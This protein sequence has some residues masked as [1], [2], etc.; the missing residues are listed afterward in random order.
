MNVSRARA[1]ASV[2]FQMRRVA[3]DSSTAPMERDALQQRG[4]R[5]CHTRAEYLVTSRR[6]AGKTRARAMPKDKG[7][8][9]G[10]GKSKGQT[11]EDVCLKC[12]QRGHCRDT[13]GG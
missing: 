1:A 6:T 5:K 4:D 9:K 10:K 12:G 13:R 11:D 3:N 7:G 8:K 2:A